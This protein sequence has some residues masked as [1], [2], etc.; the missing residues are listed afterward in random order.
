MLGGVVVAQTAATTLAP[1]LIVVSF[2]FFLLVWE[3]FIFLCFDV[4]LICETSCFCKNYTTTYYT[5]LYHVTFP[6]SMIVVLK[7]SRDEQS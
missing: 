3:M 4:V 1:A 5:N 2:V 6:H 7:I